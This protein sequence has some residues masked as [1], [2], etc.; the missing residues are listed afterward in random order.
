M[1]LYCLLVYFL[2]SV[3]LCTVNLSFNCA[4][5]LIHLTVD[6]NGCVYLS[7]VLELISLLWQL[8]MERFVGIFTLKAL[9]LAQT[10]IF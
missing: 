8:W 7:Q 3:H 4:S 2:N 5:I 6:K 10:E 1:K 9:L